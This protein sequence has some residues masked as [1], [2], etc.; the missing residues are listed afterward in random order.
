MNMSSILAALAAIESQVAAVR[1]VISTEAKPIASKSKRAS[2][3]QAPADAEAPAKPKREINPKIAAMN[4]ER[5]VIFKEMKD[6]WTSANS[7]FASLDS[8]EL[9]K[10]I[11]EGRVAKPPSFPDAIKEH[12]RRLRENDPE[13]EA[14]HQTYLA[15]RAKK[16]AVASASAAPV[17]AKPADTETV[18]SGN[19]SDS[20]SKRGP[21]P[22]FKL[23]DEEKA[24][25]AEKRKQNAAA[26][27]IAGVPPLPPSPVSDA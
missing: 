26:K 27:K 3:K 6:A 4:D 21:K 23:S 16:D 10:A 18:A 13:A 2:A 5:K 24:K 11:T 25:R 7:S 9:K 1:S 8:A 14:R 22:G 17:A 15:K 20:K 19:T 12:S